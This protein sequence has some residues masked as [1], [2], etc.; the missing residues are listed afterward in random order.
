V[1]PIIQASIEARLD[2]W[3]DIKSII[4]AASVIG[5]DFFRCSVSWCPNAAA[6]CPT[7]S[8]GWSMRAC[9][10]RTGRAQRPDALQPCADP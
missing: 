10:Y 6:N 1:P 5:R 7:R 8:R 9:W 3:S 2:R 4:Q